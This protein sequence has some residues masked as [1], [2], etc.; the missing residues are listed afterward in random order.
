[1]TDNTNSNLTNINEIREVS[2]A[3][4][5]D[6]L[7]EIFSCLRLPGVTYD[8]LISKEELLDGTWVYRIYQ[9]D[10][11]SW[12]R[13]EE[14]EHTRLRALMADTAITFNGGNQISAQSKIQK[15]VKVWGL[16]WDGKS[17]HGINEVKGEVAPR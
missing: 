17:P 16:Y 12:R 15:L 7:E 11:V 3:S 10:G 2:P 1:M 5:S 4:K 13:I 14:F 6:K 9:F 8:F